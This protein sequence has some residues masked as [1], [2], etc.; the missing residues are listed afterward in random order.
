MI[1]HVRTCAPAVLA[2]GLASLFL[3]SAQA[4]PEALR[5]PRPPAVASTSA[6]PVRIDCPATSTMD[7]PATYLAPGWFATGHGVVLRRLKLI[8]YQGKQEL[9]CEYDLTS[10]PNSYATVLRHPVPLGSCV[11]G[12]DEAWFQCRAG[13]PK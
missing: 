2:A 10:V 6:Y 13:T 8:E 12:P 4:A 5:A 3:P 11:M 1:P 9:N 7:V